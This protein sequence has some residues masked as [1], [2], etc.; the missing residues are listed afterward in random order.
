MKQFVIILFSVAMF[1]KCSSKSQAEVVED[2]FPVEYYIVQDTDGWSNLRETPGGTV[3]KKVFDYEKFKVIGHEKKHKKIK[4]GNGTIGY[5]HKS[6]VVNLNDKICE[7]IKKGKKI[8]DANKDYDPI[9][10]WG[11][12]I[13]DEPSLSFRLE[14]IFLYGLCPKGCQFLQSNEDFII[15]INSEIERCK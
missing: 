7:C 13:T 1:V 9:M 5:I 2:E 10:G 15:N 12:G 8:V 14:Q 11:D 3:L 4:L 6:R